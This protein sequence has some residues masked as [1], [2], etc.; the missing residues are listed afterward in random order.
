MILT[1]IT[2]LYSY[3]AHGVTESNALDHM[4]S[5][6]VHY[7]PRRIQLYYTAHY[8]YLYQLNIHKACQIQLDT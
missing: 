8:L 7:G 1:R 5:G 4:A 2:V 3:I 6:Q